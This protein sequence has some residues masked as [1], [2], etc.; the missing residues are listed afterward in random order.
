MTMPHERLR[1]IGW[2]CELLGALQRDSSVPNELQRAAER[3]QATYPASQDLLELLTSPGQAFPVGASQAIEEARV[4][5]ERARQLG[6]GTDVTRRQLLFT[7]RHFPSKG[8][9]A[10]ADQASRQG[11]LDEW[12]APE[13]GC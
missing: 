2:G 9:G 8:W 4:L 10:T 5:F 7:M 13:P 6:A 3:L 1:S 12:L 11:R